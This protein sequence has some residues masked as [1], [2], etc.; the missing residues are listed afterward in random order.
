MI[1][2]EKKAGRMI[3]NQ[4]I[5]FKPG[6]SCNN[7]CI[8]CK[9][10][11]IR[12]DL[13]TEEAKQRI[14]SIAENGRFKMIFFSGGESTI[15]KDFFELIEHA[16]KSGLEIGIAT[17][18]RMLSHDKF[19][20]KFRIF[21]PKTIFASFPSCKKEVFNKITACNSFEQSINGLK[22]AILIGSELIVNIV[23]SRLNH[24]YLPDIVKFLI[25]NKVRMITISRFQKSLDSEYLE[26]DPEAIRAALLSIRE[27]VIKKNVKF[28][29]DSFDQH[30]LISLF[31]NTESSFHYYNLTWAFEPFEQEIKPL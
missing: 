22:N 16:R 28:F 7:Q 25:E 13:S 19:S 3:E 9:A 23:L 4:T 26:I 6:Y 31:G 5:L 8:Y 24:E 2:M 21:K 11:N 17:N 30:L 29:F 18:L 10:K 12:Y 14:S 15:R 27:Q 1:V 20:K